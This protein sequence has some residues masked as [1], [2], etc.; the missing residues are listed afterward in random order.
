MSRTTRELFN[1]KMHS[2]NALYPEN[3][4]CFK[5]GKMCDNAWA[6]AF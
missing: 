3:N 1:A 5:I 4:K 6:I 2:K